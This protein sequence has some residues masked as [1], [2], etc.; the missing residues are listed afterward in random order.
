MN[1]NTF[2]EICLVKSIFF[3]FTK[4][5]VKAF[6]T[7]FYIPIHANNTKLPPVFEEIIHSTTL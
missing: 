5:P 7:T 2:G 4:A 1:Q 6:T 3:L